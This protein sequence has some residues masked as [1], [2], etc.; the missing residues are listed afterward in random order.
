MKR[1]L[2]IRFLLC[3]LTTFAALLSCG[4]CT[5]SADTTPPRVT[6]S[7]ALHGVPAPLARKLTVATDEPTRVT[8]TL[9]DS[10]RG[11]KNEIDFEAYSTSHELP[12]LG[13]KFD[14]AYTVSITVTDRAGNR[15]DAGQ[16]S[17]S[18]ISAPAVFPAITKN[19]T[20]HPNAEP[21]VLLFTAATQHVS[22]FVGYAYIIIVDA[23][24][25]VIWYYDP[26]TEVS[27]LQRLANG[28]LLVQSAPYHH[29]SVTEIDMLGQTVRTWITRKNPHYN[30]PPA[31]AIKV[32]IDTVHHDLVVLPNGNYVTMSTEL[33]H[34]DDFPTTETNINQTLKP[35]NFVNTT[36]AEFEP[37][38]GKVVRRWGILEAGTENIK[39]NPPLNY[40]RMGYQSLR[41]AFWAEIYGAQVG[42][43]AD[44]CGINGIDP[45]T[46]AGT[47][48][49]WDHANALWY[50]ESTNSFLFGARHQAAILNFRADTGAVNWILGNHAYWPSALEPY[51]L[52]PPA[53]ATASF[54]PYYPHRLTITKAR[55]IM[56]MDNHNYEAL[57]PDAP[58][59]AVKNNSRVA[60]YRVENGKVD[61]AWEYRYPVVPG[62]E[63]N[64]NLYAPSIGSA[65]E[66]AKTG[67][68]LIDFGGICKVPDNA[69]KAPQ[70]MGN[71]GEPTNDNNTCKHWGRILEVTH[72]GVKTLVFDIRVGN[73]DIA[74]PLGWNVYRAMKLPRLQP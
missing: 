25:D 7:A 10:N 13:M 27:A 6:T 19:I 37:N 69:I 72:D 44:A 45:A 3:S 18:P 62:D 49:D 35:A 64:T 53:S 24:G 38:S 30:D 52:N 1:H 26:S 11:T 58:L 41:N 36:L 22:K 20:G 29:T 23:N 28:N 67:N 15:T 43:N 17:I 5:Q 12:V 32:D 63:L 55:T 73:N 31:G 60:E 54:W 42:G 9:S 21:G 46:G 8:V 61:L 50:D 68:I 57:P 71:P 70:E 65:L 16:L 56:M 4:D 2:N 66:M 48:R 14:T 40:K 33:R 47:C 39:M 34:V 74:D 51:L 59:P